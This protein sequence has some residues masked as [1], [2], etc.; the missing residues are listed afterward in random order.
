MINIRN[1][2]ELLNCK[3]LNII[4]I[5]HHICGVMTCFSFVLAFF[6]P[7]AKAFKLKILDFFL[8]CTL[9]GFGLYKD[10][11]VLSLKY[12]FSLVLQV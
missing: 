12:T 6:L 5:F 8:S 3:S 7:L 2:E 9:K 10:I 4:C 11:S 1:K